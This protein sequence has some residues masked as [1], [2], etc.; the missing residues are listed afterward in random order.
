MHKALKG[1]RWNLFS[2]KIQSR[3]LAEKL[4]SNVRLV[5]KISGS[6]CE[7]LHGGLVKVC[8]T[9]K[10]DRALGFGTEKLQ[11]CGE[12]NLCTAR[13]RESKYTTANG[14]DSYAAELSRVTFGQ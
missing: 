3:S 1:A 12:K 2:I 11:R 14:G 13:L 6:F 10:I 5:I 9:N 7:H 4:D 8:K